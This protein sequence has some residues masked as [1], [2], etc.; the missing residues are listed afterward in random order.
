M[1]GRHRG[2]KC[3]LRDDVAYTAHVLQIILIFSSLESYQLQFCI[4]RAYF[5]C[6]IWHVLAVCL[7]MNV[8]LV[9]R[10]VAPPGECYYSTLLCSTTIFHC[11]VWYHALSLRYPCIRSSGIILIPRYFCTKFRFFAASIAELAH[12]EKSRSQSENHSLTSIFDTPGTEACA[13]ERLRNTL[14]N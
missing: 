3:K 4:P 10:Y 14:E 12:G 5:V 9:C 6:T 8:T 11:R 2:P 13:S 7:C 1:I